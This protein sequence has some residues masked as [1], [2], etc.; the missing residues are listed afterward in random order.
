MWWRLFDYHDLW[1]HS[2]GDVAASGK[3]SQRGYKKSKIRWSLTFQRPIHISGGSMLL[4]KSTERKSRTS[5]MKGNAPHSGK[6]LLLCSTLLSSKVLKS[7]CRNPTYVIC[8]KSSSDFFLTADAVYLQKCTGHIE[9]SC[10]HWTVHTSFTSSM[11]GK[12]LNYSCLH[13]DELNRHL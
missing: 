8:A 10:N 13:V 5:W 11:R 6:R 2:G 4:F 9:H 3:I 1:I 7:T 12:N